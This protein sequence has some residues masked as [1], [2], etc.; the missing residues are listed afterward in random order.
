MQVNISS[1]LSEIITNYSN[2]QNAVKP[3]DYKAN[4]P[5]QIRLQNEFKQYYNDQFWFEIKR[6]ELPGKG[7]VVTNEYT[8]LMLMSFDL[9][10]P[11]GT[12]RKYQVFDEKHAELF[13]RPEVSAD[14]IVMCHEMMKAISNKTDKIN[15]GLFGKYGITKHVLLYMLRTILETDPLGRELLV[16]PTKFV[17]LPE[18]REH[19]GDCISKIVDDMVIDVNAEVDEL[20]DDFDYRG[21][22]RDD[23]WVKNLSKNVVGNYQKLVQRKRIDSFSTEWSRRNQ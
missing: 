2:N 12:H 14:R 11:W 8:G 15:N 22:L 1:E 6:G 18:E 5:I 3:R 13:G 7:E 4:D 23:N 19:F 16:N 17:R 9:K 20:G 21:K 10:E